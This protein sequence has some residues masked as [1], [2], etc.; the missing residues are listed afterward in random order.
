MVRNNGHYLFSLQGNRKGTSTGKSS[1]E[2]CCTVF[3]AMN[4]SLRNL[5]YEG[6][7]LDSSLA[8]ATWLLMR[9]HLT[10]TF[11]DPSGRRMFFTDNFNTWQ[12][13]A[14]ELKSLNDREAWIV[15]SV[16]FTNVDGTNFSHSKKA[17]QEVK[18]AERAK[19]QLLRVY[20][21]PFDIEKLKKEHISKMSK[22][23]K[24]EHTNLFHL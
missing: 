12:N 16:K 8:S 1:P 10:K 2:C 22:L 4:A 17:I 23:P 9:S 14:E 11:S 21:K 3:S 5:Y 15:A 24:T 7:K 6:S 19:W 20:G 13:I 18:D